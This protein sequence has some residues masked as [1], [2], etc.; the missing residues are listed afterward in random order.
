M[1]CTMSLLK[2]PVN[3]KHVSN[4]IIPDPNISKC[5]SV[6]LKIYFIETEKKT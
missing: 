4:S 1:C 3:Y 2:L 5:K 6:L